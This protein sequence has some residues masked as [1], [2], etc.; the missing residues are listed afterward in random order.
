MYL[1]PTLKKDLLFSK[2]HLSMKSYYYFALG[3]Q[4]MDEPLGQKTLR[5][6]IL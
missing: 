5:I 6:Q 3:T 4:G 2:H 1:K